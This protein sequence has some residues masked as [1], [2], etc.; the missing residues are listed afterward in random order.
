MYAR[1]TILGL[2]RGANKCHIIRAT[3]E[4]IAYQTKDV[5]NAMTEDSCI[6]ISS[7]NVDGGATKNNFL[8]Q[9]QSD[10]LDKNVNMPTIRET[11]ALGAAYLAGL[12]VGFWS[13]QEEIISCHKIAKIYYPNMGEDERNAKYDKWKKAI[14]KSM[15]WDV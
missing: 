13:D 11:T 12:S 6:P 7:L 14:E 5:L 1:G 3:L 2:S 9:F 8:M 15:A 10:I 4:A